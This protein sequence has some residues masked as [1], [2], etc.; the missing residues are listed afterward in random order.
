MTQTFKDRVLALADDFARAQQAKDGAYAER[1]MVV[2]ALVAL[3][4][5]QGWTVGLAIHDPM[6]A[7]WEDEWRNIVFIDLPTGQVS[8]HV[9]DAQMSL[10]RSLP[11]YAGEWDG[12][13]T[14]EKYKRLAAL[15]YWVHA[16]DRATAAEPLPPELEAA[17]KEHE[18]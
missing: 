13:T 8:W 7:A 9:H 6:D 14:P 16:K 2:G 11:W 15:S 18:G 4:V 12:H 10:F 1:N 17:A 3:A 5:N